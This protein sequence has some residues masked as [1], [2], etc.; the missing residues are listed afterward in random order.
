MGSVA[1]PPLGDGASTSIT[2]GRAKLWELEDSAA[3]AP[4]AEGV[5]REDDG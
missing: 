4:I 1:R 3:G 5:A 2:L